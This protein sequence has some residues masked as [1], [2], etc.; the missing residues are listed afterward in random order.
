VRVEIHSLTNVVLPKPAAAEISVTR[1]PI[2]NPSFS[3]SIKRGRGTTPGRDGG[4]YS[5][6]ARIGAGMN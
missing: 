3:R 6:V 4:M 2:A 5:F 1:Q